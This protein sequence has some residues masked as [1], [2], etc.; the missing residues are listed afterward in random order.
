[1]NIQAKRS[2][3]FGT[4]HLLLLTVCFIISFAL[5]MDRLDAG[6]MDETAM[7]FIAGSLTN[8]LM[9]PGIYLWT[10]WA[11]KNL[12]NIFEWFLFLGN[13]GLWGVTLAYVYGKIIKTHNQSGSAGKT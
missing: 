5:G 9:A 8:I 10:P 7:D 3:A 12:P 2:L 11:S 1:M 13:S 6:E 4:A